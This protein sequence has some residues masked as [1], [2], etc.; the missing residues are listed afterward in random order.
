MEKTRCNFCGAQLESSREFIFQF[1][2]LQYDPRTLAY[3]RR[4]PG[5][6]GEPLRLC[7]KCNDGIEQNNLERK[8]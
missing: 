4:M 8:E 3:I 2:S 7:K 1:E 5:Y 6:R